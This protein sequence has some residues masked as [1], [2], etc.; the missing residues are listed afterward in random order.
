MEAAFVGP[1]ARCRALGA[2]QGGSGASGGRHGDSCGIRGSAWRA[3]PNT[4][5]CVPGGRDRARRRVACQSS[6][7]R[8]VSDAGLDAAGERSAGAVAKSPGWYFVGP[9]VVVVLVRDWRGRFSCELSL[10]KLLL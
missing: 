8:I 10:P 7:Q 2:V 9:V 4:A 5:P 3:R 6:R 1:G